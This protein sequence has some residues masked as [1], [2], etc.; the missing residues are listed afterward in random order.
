MVVAKKHSRSFEQ[1]DNSADEDNNAFWLKKRRFGGQQTDS[2][3]RVARLRR[4]VMGFGTLIL[5]LA[6]LILYMSQNFVPKAELAKATPRYRLSTEALGTAAVPPPAPAAPAPAPMVQLLMTKQAIPEGIQLTADM[7]NT[8]EV[9]AD[10][11]PQGAVLEKD[12]MKVVGKYASRYIEPNTILMHESVSAVGAGSL[13]PFHIPAGYRAVSIRVD[14]RTGVEGFAKPGTY[15]D[16]LWFYKDK[17][18]SEKV[19]RIVGSAKIVSVGGA[20]DMMAQPQ[21]A[22]KGMTTVTLL[23]QK[24]ESKIIELAQNIGSLTLSLVGENDIGSPDPED[25]YPV[26]ARDV[27]RWV[28]VKNGKTPPPD[29]MLVTRDPRTG[30][31]KKYVLD[32]DGW[33]EEAKAAKAE[34]LSSEVKPESWIEQFKK[35]QRPLRYQK[36]IGD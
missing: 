32:R 4:L 26:T 9:P 13:T 28:N 12:G 14:S 7:F 1:V 33:M 15:V 11:M 27:V 34:G 8:E 3:Y 23:V 21:E 31:A 36:I 19:S 16:V 24:R 6:G 17:N 20:T 2:L 35:N 29:G 5:V 10:T 18:G 22:T 25:Q 30:E